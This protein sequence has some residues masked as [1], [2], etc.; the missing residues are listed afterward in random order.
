[1]T[2]NIYLALFFAAMAAGTASAQ[3]Q[4]RQYIRTGNDQYGEKDYLN[5]EISYRKALEVNATDSIAKFNLG[6]SLYRQQKMEDAM[7]QYVTTAQAAQ[8]SGNKDL[9]AQSYFNAGNIYMAAQDYGKAE[10]LFRQSLRMNPADDEARYNLVLASKLK[11]QQQQDQ[12][13]DQ[14]QDQDQN[15]QQQDQQQQQQDQNKNQDQNKDQNQDQ[16]KQE[17]QNQDQEQQQ[18]QQQA[19]AS[20]S[21]EQVESI[22]DAANQEEKA[23]QDKVK[24]KLMEQVSRKRTD[25]DW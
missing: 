24:A 5:A 12:N 21:P 9:A 6:N 2:K 15:Q 11:Q 18:Q 1:M 17:P 22:L 8:R 16:Q 13:Q 3:K 7:K 19:Q 14:N 23:V 10:E 20:M 4:V 25:K